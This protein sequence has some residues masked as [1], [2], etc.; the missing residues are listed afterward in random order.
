M[1]FRFAR[2]TSPLRS[3]VS[4]SWPVSQASAA[5]R[6]TRVLIVRSH[7][8]TRPELSYPNHDLYNTDHMAAKDKLEDED[9]LSDRP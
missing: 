8:E 6:S 5:R 2:C 7:D 3:E 4:E 1:C 9:E